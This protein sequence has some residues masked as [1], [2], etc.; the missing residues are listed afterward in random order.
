MPRTQHSTCTPSIQQSLGLVP[1]HLQSPFTNPPPL[2]P[3][4]YERFILLTGVAEAQK[5]RALSEVPAP[6]SVV[7][8]GPEPRAHSLPL[9][10]SLTKSPKVITISLTGGKP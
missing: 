7:K 8:A 4:A 1:E 10:L 2:V 5:G 9:S 3:T 6:A